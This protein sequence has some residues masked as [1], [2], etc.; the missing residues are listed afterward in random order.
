[1]SVS[2][3]DHGPWGRLPTTVRAIV[4]GL[5][6]GLIGANVWSLLLVGFGPLVA[7]IVEPLFLILYLWWASGHGPPRRTLGARRRAFRAPTL[8]AAGWIWGLIAAVAFAASVH[9]A[10]VILFRLTP[11]PVAE[12]RRGYDLSYFGGPALRWIVVVIAAASAG[13]CEETGF[14]GYLQQPLEDRFGPRW[15]VLASSVF[16]ALAHLNKGWAG[17]GM[18]PIIF[19]AGLLLG[20]L[21]W[22]SRSLAPVIIGHTIMDIGLFAY[23][24]TGIAGTF[25]ARPIGESGADPAFVVAVAVFAVAVGVCLT[26]IWRLRRIAP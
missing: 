10:M 9:A 5:A 16:F 17:L 1:M 14:R 6:I 3:V 19:G 12:F 26:S 15:A 11:F 8:S 22:A 24:W 2:V 25:T 7:A 18:V 20:A 4:A 13:V 21:A 23:W